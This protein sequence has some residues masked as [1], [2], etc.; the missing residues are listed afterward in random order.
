[1]FNLIYCPTEHQ[2]ADIL[3]K[4]LARPNFGEFLAKI[5]ATG[6]PSCFCGKENLN[7]FIDRM[8][9]LSQLQK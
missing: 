5:G 8:P 6:D 4:P 9:I 7:T 3:T 2:I 1:M